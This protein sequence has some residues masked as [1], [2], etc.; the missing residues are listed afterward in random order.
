MKTLDYEAISSRCRC[1]YDNYGVRL[2]NLQPSL[3]LAPY[4]AIRYNHRILSN[5]SLT[6]LLID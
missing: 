6:V 3:E 4:S 2:T 5:S 1:Y